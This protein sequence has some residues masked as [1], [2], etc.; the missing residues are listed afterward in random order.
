MKTHHVRRQAISPGAVLPLLTA[1]SPNMV[2]AQNQLV[3]NREKN[4][5]LWQAGKADDSSAEFGDYDAGAKGVV[6]AA[7]ALAG[8]DWKSVPKGL[9]ASV[10]PA[11]TIRYS[12]RAVPANGIE[13][14]FKLL[15]A[16]KNG[17]QMAV[18]S[19]GLMAGLIQLWGMADT[20][21]PHRWK[22][23]YR[24]YIPKEMLLRGENAL[25]LQA[26]RPLWSDAKADPFVWW[27]WD[28]LRLAA[29]GAPATEPMHGKM[30]WLGTTIKQS[31]NNFNYDARTLAITPVMCQWLGIAY[32]NNPIRADFWHDVSGQQPMRMEFLKELRDLNM[33]VVADHISSYH[34]SLEADGAL[35]DKTKTDIAAFFTT[36]GSL[37]QFY[38]LANEPTGIMGNSKWG[39]S[40]AALMIL[41]RYINS[42]KPAHVKTTAPGWAYTD[43]V[44]TPPGW[45]RNPAMRRQ[46]EDLCQATNGHS[47]GFS[48]AD[49]AGGS[50]V[51]NLATYGG[52]SDGWPKPFVNTETGTNNW[53]SESNGTRLPSR[54]EHAAAFDRIMRAHVAVV[55]HTI[56][57]A[58]IFDDFGLFAAP[59]NWDDVTTLTAFPGV[60]GEDTRLKTF[61]RL[62]LAYATHG[63]PLPFR[64]LN[65]AAVAGKKVLLRAVDT[66]ALAPL[67]GSSARSDKVLLNFVNFEETPQTL[68]VR[69]TLPAKSL[70]SGLRIGAGDTY[71]AS[72]SAVRFNAAPVLDL[73]VALG[74]GESVQYILSRSAALPAP[75]PA[76]SNASPEA[77]A[78]LRYLGGIS[79]RRILSGQHNYTM[80]RSS[81]SDRAGAIAGKYPAVWGSDFGH[82][83][84]SL[85]QRQTMIDEAKRQ[86]A[87]GGIITLMWHA[88]RP[89][90]EETAGWKESVQSQLTPEQW[91]ELMTPNTPLHRRWLAQV[92]GI[93]AYLRQLRDAKIPV[94][95]RPYHE[96]NGGWFWW[97]QKKGE[98]G[99]KALWRLMHDRLTN[100]H[101]L[102]NLL[103]V[104][105]A[106]APNQWADPYAEYYPGH[107]YVD[108]LAVDVYSAD[109]KQSHYNDLLKLAAGRPI[110]L[111]EVGEMPTASVLAT[112]PKWTWFMTWPSHLE[113][114]NKPEGIKA[115][116]NDARVLT[117]DEVPA[118]K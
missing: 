61:R 106:N 59:T 112:Q 81:Y 10:N 54:Q 6:I 63:R 79:G 57:H 9:K 18:F 52:V 2:F 102:N 99:Y 13:L 66:S 33:T 28:Y 82:G 16:H 84:E 85:A 8:S 73:N 62:A 86:H 98:R 3:N 58:S 77:R 109:Y 51:E 67:P 87:Q 65:T 116:F 92:D 5:P 72:H 91:N 23:T 50:F 104:W 49:N 70:Y 95:W 46:I 26:P 41:A 64:V 27:E 117:R 83:P 11:L 80:N 40:H 44:G 97:G 108:V 32:S 53:H 39:G 4:I 36:Y 14:S 94:L 105:N 101:Q 93:A 34:A 19:N 90:D 107:A 114:N 37:F 35:S 60:S 111:G 42:I 56:Q 55:D 22:K 89:I 24:L 113:E 75:G 1:L 110:A 118:R 17:P 76:N 12:L 25:Q 78:L 38:E 68:R 74:S 88:V 96:M 29:L 45:E 100:H 15:H 43:K 71:A 69:V 7:N 31:A 48:Y 21:S 47:Y 103:W 20:T 30:A 115:L